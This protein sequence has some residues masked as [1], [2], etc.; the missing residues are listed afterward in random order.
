MKTAIGFKRQQRHITA[1]LKLYSRTIV[2]LLVV[3]IA[4]VVTRILNYFA[5]GKENKCTYIVFMLGSTADIILVP[6]T[7][8]KGVR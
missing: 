6:S 8:G 5:T 7:E 4:T 3:I 2:L 1:I